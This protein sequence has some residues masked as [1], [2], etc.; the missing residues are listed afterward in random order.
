M[1]TLAELKAIPH[2]VT[3]AR[4]DGLDSPVRIRSATRAQVRA[5]FDAE[6]GDEQAIAWSVVDSDGAPLFASPAECADLDAAVFGD[7]ARAIVA[8]NGF[9]R[10][11]K[12]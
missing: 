7:L 5:W 11:E 1:A 9:A 3:E 2:R 12:R 6:D 4:I 10:R 8:A